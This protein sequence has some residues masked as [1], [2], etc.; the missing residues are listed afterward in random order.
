MKICILVA[1]FALFLLAQSVPA[2][3]QSNFVDSDSN[4]VEPA[5]TTATSLHHYRE[6]RSTRNARKSPTHE[7]SQKSATFLQWLAGI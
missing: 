4:S 2:Q 3:A 1:S 6:L 7:R 5:I